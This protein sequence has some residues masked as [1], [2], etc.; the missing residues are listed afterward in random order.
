MR[1]LVAAATCC[2]L[3]C[4]SPARSANA[5]EAGAIDTAQG[6]VVL[7]Q[8]IGPLKYVGDRQFDDPLLG[9][10]YSYRADGFSLDIYIYQGTSGGATDGVTGAGTRNEYEA[11]KQTVLATDAYASRV[12]IAERQARLGTT[13]DAPEA[14]EAA[15]DLQLRGQRLRSFLWVTAANGYYVKARFSMNGDFDLEAEPAREHVLQEL[16]AAVTDAIE[17]KPPLSEPAKRES[18]YQ[19]RFE[20]KV[21]ESEMPFWLLYLLAR[22]SWEQQQAGGSVA[23]VGPRVATF[24]EEVFARGKAVSAFA[25]TLDVKER[26]R[27][28]RDFPYFGELQRVIEAGYLREYVWFEL[29]HESWLTDPADI[30]ASEYQEWRARHLP[31]HVPVT[32]GTLRLT[33]AAH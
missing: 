11:A 30:R 20:S 6:G 25:E 2:V 28:A 14:L 27:V 1:S 23:G 29:R 4:S 32:H 31:N 24:D 19:I 17:R 7:P 22:V 8:F 21:A 33:S 3:L 10:A 26:K 5:A 9:K 13:D 15:F 16:G 18:Q 12:L